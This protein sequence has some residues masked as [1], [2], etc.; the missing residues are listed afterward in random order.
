MEIALSKGRLSLRTRLN[1]ILARCLPVASFSFFGK[2]PIGHGERS[3]SEIG[4]GT[5]EGC[6]LNRHLL[7]IAP[8]QANKKGTD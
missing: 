6:P 5:D 3:G 8:N 2:A 4:K 1:G 7:S